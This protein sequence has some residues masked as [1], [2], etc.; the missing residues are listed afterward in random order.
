[1]RIYWKQ[2]EFTRIADTSESY[3][4]EPRE[5]RARQLSEGWFAKHL[6]RLRYWH[7]T[8][9][10]ETKTKMRDVLITIND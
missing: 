8:V 4:I 1:M 3:D 7:R 6:L 9:A 5:Y 2:N 10:A